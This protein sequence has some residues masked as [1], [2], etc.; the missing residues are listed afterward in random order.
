MTFPQPNYLLYPIIATN[1]IR[2]VFAKA[3]VG[4]TLYCLHEAA[5]IASGYDYSRF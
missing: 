2:Q 4:K 1:Q 5:S 3:G